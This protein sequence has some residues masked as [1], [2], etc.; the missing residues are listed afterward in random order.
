MSFLKEL[1]KNLA[2]FAIIML[3]VAGFIFLLLLPVIL[4][5]YVADWLAYATFALYFLLL[6]AGYTWADR[7]DK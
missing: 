1:L 2:A 3:A 5:E 6:V 7:N 4:G